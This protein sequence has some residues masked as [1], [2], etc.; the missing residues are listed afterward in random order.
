[1]LMQRSK[2][3]MQMMKRLAMTKTM[4]SQLKRLL[5]KRMLK[6]QKTMLKTMQLKSQ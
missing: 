3:A 6:S 1:M 4:E 2:T 5:R